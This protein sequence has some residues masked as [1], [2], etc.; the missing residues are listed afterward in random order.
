MAGGSQQEKK[1]EQAIAALLTTDTIC[2]AAAQIGVSERTL[3]RWLQ[4]EDFQRAY[5]EAR[6]QVVQHAIV[7]MQRCTG[8]AV[9]ALSDVMTNPEASASARV[10]AA[11]SVLQLALQNCSCDRTSFGGSASTWNFPFYLWHWQSAMKMARKMGDAASMGRKECRFLLK[12]ETS[13]G[14][15]G[16]RSDA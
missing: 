16:N 7:R 3:L 4:E 5:R 8:E 6:R 1:R 14:H 12:W 11:R 10:S 15:N 2:A 13:P 9:D